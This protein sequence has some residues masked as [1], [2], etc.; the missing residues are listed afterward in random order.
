M[1]IMVLDLIH[2]LGVTTVC[3][4]IASEMVLLCVFHLV[5]GSWTVDFVHEQVC[6]PSNERNIA[7]LSAEVTHNHPEGIKGDL[8]TSDAIFMCR[9]YFGG[10]S[11][12]YGQPINDN[13]KECKRRIKDYIEK[14]YGYDL[15]QTL[16]ETSP[17]Y[18]FNEACQDTVPQAI[19]AFLESTDFEDAIRNAISLVG[20][21]DTLAAITGSIAEAAYGIPDWIKD[22]AYTYLDE[23]FKDI[24]GRWEIYIAGK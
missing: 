23:P 24:I 13:P 14:E 18:R 5:L 15:S 17:S 19:I 6:W 4:T 2:G 22:K 21:S 1:R 16:D 7:R 3:H 9:Y 12:D 10:Y 20:D 11:A 8:A